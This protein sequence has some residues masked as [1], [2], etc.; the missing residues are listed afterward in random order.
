VGTGV[1]GRVQ[2][3]LAKIEFEGPVSG[4]LPG[5]ELEVGQTIPT[6][7]DQRHTVVGDA[8]FHDPWRDF[9]VGTILRYGSG[10]PVAEGGH[11]TFTYLP[12]HT[13]LDIMTRIDL[14][15]SGEQQVV[16]ELD[17]TNVTDNVY[18][19]AKESEFTPIQYAPRRTVRGQIRWNF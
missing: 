11:E 9:E 10:T 14:W 19:I 4:G 2:Y 17:V 12:G 16:F 3:S 1:S 7:F 18:Q 5:E 8:R 15:R 13:T 6:A